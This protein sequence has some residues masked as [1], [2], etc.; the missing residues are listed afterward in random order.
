MII[1]HHKAKGHYERLRFALVYPRQR[2]FNFVTADDLYGAMALVGIEPLDDLDHGL[3]IA[4]TEEI[5]YGF[6]AVS[7]R[8]AIFTDAAKELWGI[9][10][11]LYAG[12]GVVYA[13]TLSERAVDVPDAVPVRFFESV[14][15]IEAEIAGKRL[16]RP[17]LWEGAAIKWTW[18]QPA[19]APMRLT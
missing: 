4:A 13:H 8:Q 3:V 1:S 14:A 15:E 11:R 9:G 16:D 2:R 10:K 17:M 12:P 6:S 7:K 19:P 18:P 5:T